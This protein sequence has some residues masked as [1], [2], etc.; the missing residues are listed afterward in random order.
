MTVSTVQ[1]LSVPAVSGE[2]HDQPVRHLHQVDV[3]RRWRISERTLEAW[4]WRRKGPPYLRIGGRIAYRLTDIEAYE[5]QSFHQ[6]RN[7]DEAK[8]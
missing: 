8:R 1:K 4:R 2:A 5:A 7:G 3:A 6:P